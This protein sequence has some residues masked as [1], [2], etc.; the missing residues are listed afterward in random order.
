M[1]SGD[2]KQWQVRL[3][4]SHPH[5][6]QCRPAVCEAGLETWHYGQAV[7]AEE[8]DGQAD[9]TQ[10]G[11]NVF[12][13]LVLF[14]FLQNP[15]PQNKLN[16][17]LPWV[18]GWSQGRTGKR[19]WLKCLIILTIILKENKQI[20]HWLFQ[21]MFKSFELPLKC[22]GLLLNRRFSSKLLLITITSSTL[23]ENGKKVA[24]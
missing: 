14:F 18:V 4:E 1:S 12:C 16:I 17:L 6:T 11:K 2:E 24:L 9:F 23:T 13:C 15:P 20:L 3:W 8:E 7:A 22:W 10:G 19:C 5:F 21:K